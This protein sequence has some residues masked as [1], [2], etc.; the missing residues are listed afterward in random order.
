V[1]KF[2]AKTV[3]AYRKGLKLDLGSIRV[4]MKGVEGL[5]ELIATLNALPGRAQTNLYRRAIRPAL[6]AVAKEAKALVHNVPV[7]SGQETKES[8]ADGSIRDDIAKAIKVKVGIKLK[9][10]VYGSVAVRYPKR[11]K[12]Q[13]SPG[14]KAS[15]AHLI[16][17]G[18]TLKVAF[19]GKPRKQPI[20][21]EGAEFMT[22][23]F[24]RIAPRAQRLFQSAM[25]ELI[26]NPGVGKKDFATK[27]EA[28]V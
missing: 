18:F 14:N 23:A 20:A 4:Q 9:K 6:T 12:G 10:G 11:A 8:K 25:Q 16:E 7:T 27:M 13:N 17:F 2:A 5:D 15:L 3:D 1:S 26:R 19:Y 28:V 22:S 24:E 21:I